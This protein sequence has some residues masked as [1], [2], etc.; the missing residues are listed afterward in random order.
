MDEVTAG[1]APGSPQGWEALAL[2]AVA[3][4]VVMAL[5]PWSRRRVRRRLARVAEDWERRGPDDAPELAMRA[6]AGRFVRP[7]LTQLESEEALRR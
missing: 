3:S 6:A 7:L 4:A 1:G 2:L 5:P